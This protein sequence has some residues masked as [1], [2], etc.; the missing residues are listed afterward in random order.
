MGQADYI[1]QQRVQPHPVPGLISLY[2]SSLIIKFGSR[3]ER[4]TS[5]AIC[6]LSLVS[7]HFQRRVLANICHHSS[8]I[9]ITIYQKEEQKR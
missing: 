1:I 8:V 5:L 3:L 4:N 2:L 7:T 9:I 6:E